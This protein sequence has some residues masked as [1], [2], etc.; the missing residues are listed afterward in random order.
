[1]HCISIFLNF[2]DRISSSAIIFIKQITNMLSEMTFVNRKCNCNKLD[3]IITDSE[4]FV[5]KFEIKIRGC[6]CR[7]C[8]YL[9]LLIAL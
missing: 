2:L 8:G 7:H 5:I 9:Y 6:Y 1:M 4:K 3:Q